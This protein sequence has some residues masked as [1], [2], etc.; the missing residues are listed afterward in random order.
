MPSVLNNA[1]STPLVQMQ[2]ITINGTP[3]Y[4]RDTNCC[5]TKDEIMAMPTIILVPTPGKNN[6]NRLL[7]VGK[8]YSSCTSI[9]SSLFL[10]FGF[11]N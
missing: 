9:V 2:T 3:A 6:S 4:K 11:S 5:Y 7:F 1:T 8:T 10:S